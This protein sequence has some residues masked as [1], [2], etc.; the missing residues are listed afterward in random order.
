VAVVEPVAWERFALDAPELA[1]AGRRLID[2]YHVAFLATLRQDGAP[3][4]HP[5]S[6]VFASGGMYIA[7]P[8]R[9]PKQRDLR[10]DHRFALHAMLGD[11]DEEFVVN[12]AARLDSSQELR[13]AVRQAAGHVIRD[14]DLLFELLIQR[15]LWG[16]WENVGQP[17]TRPAYRS[18]SV[19][20]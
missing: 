17:D 14:D 1:L 7:I 18:W 5:V 9:S 4:L 12:G 10:R 3:R 6:P 15:C 2:R 11:S 19:E 16:I 8:P 20:H 13:V